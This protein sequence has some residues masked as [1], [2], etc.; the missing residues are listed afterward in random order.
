DS[1]KTQFCEKRLIVKEQSCSIPPTGHDDRRVFRQM[2]QSAG[3]DVII[4]IVG[5]KHG[6][7][8]REQ[9]APDR[10]QRRFGKPRQKPRVEEECGVPLPV[11][12]GGMSEVYEILLLHDVIPM[13]LDGSR[14]RSGQTAILV[15]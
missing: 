13:S 3:I 6:G 11:E 2:E 8:F 7:R 14:R 9:S 15:Q 4:V 12:E 1:V 10:R 5:Q